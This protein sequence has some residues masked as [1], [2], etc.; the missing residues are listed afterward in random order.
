MENLNTSIK[1]KHALPAMD[2]NPHDVLVVIPTYNERENIEHIVNLALDSTKRVHV[3][4]VDDGSPD[5]TGDLADA[6]AA[7]NPRIHVMHRT[8]KQGLASAYLQGF[9]W[10][11]AQGYTYL[12][13]FDADGSH[14]AAKI[15]ELIAQLDAGAELV[16]GSRWVPGGAT[17][18]WPLS[19]QLL[20]RMAALYCRIWLNSGIRDITAG[21]RGYRADTLKTFDLSRIG[22]AGYCFQIEMAWMYERAGLPVVEVPITFVERVHGNSKMSGNIII[23]ALWRVAA[24]GIGYR[25]RGIQH[26]VTGK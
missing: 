21:F 26:V 5:G 18:N 19:R 24:W 13:E 9:E 6:M 25:S 23:E 16:L 14:P 20:S 4:V 22:A 11:Q 17:E 8:G 2:G 3:L 7:R 10:G 1:G 15:P 12:M